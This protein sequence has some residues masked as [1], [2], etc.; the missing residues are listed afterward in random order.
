MEFIKTN[1]DG[2]LLRKNKV[3][4]DTRG[5]LAEIAP[6]GSEDALLVEGI[7]N[8][9]A[10]IATGKHIARAGHLHKK[11]IENFFTISGTALWLF[12]DCRKESPTFNKYHMVIL[13]SKP[14]SFETDIPYYTIEGS[15]IAQ[16]FIPA[17]VYHVFWPLTDENVTV[18]AIASESYDKNDYDKID[19]KNYPEIR[20]RLAEFGI[21][22]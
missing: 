15:I 18:L 9:Y 21:V 3:V 8:I 4:K 16:A 13:G 1:I 5:F 14:P 22:V 10:S 20:S 6:A 11:N 7:K 19:L 12:V 2:L 17:G